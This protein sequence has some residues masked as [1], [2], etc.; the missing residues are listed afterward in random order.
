[1]SKTIPLTQGQFAVVDDEDFDRLNQWKW[2]AEYSKKLG[3]YY[4]I[5]GTCYN[6]KQRLVRMHREVMGCV[7]GDGKH[8]DHTNHDTLDNRKENLEIT[9]HRGNHQ[10]R[11]KP[12]KY[13]TGVYK[14]WGR[15]RA[16]TYV[17]GKNRHIGTY[18][19]PEEAQAAREEFLTTSV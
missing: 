18:D 5:R 11:K 3:S 17:D 10:N 6:G 12:S 19:T 15:F 2:C 16:I 1:M 7:S 14:S 8:I 13:G 4:A 9:T